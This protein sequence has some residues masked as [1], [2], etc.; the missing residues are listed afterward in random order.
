MNMFVGQ[1]G[2]CVAQALQN[3]VLHVGH[4][5]VAHTGSSLNFGVEQ[6][7]LNRKHIDSDG[8][9]PELLCFVIK[10]HSNNV[11][12]QCN[13]CVSKSSIFQF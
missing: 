9:L 12:T 5:K 8:S 4:Q 3:L 13:T 11:I 2:E 10:K 1:H 6:N 7:M